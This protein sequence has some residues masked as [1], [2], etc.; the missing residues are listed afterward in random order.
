MTQ[1]LTLTTLAALAGL[2]GA[3]FGQTTFAFDNETTTIGAGLDGQSSGSFEVGGIE[4]TASSSVGP[5][6]GTSSNFGINQPAS[7]DDTDGF[8]FT[9]SGGPGVAENFTLSFDQAVTLVSFDVSSFG[10]S[11]EITLLDGATTIATITSTGSTSL[12]NYLL[13]ASSSISVNTTAGS[14]ANGWSF[15]SITVVPEPSTFG[16]LAGFTGLIF[17]MLKRRTT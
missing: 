4:I 12:G 14:Y 10:T 1:K 17:V 8:D 11:D 2:A 16:L 3:A 9:E 13:G 5:F 15:D 6:N 7:G